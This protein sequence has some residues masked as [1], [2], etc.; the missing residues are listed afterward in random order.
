ME[1]QHIRQMTQ[2][3]GCSGFPLITDDDQSIRETEYRR[4]SS[5]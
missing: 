4:Q 3:T 2:L 1:E 5:S